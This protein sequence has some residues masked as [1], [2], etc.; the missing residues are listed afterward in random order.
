MENLIN[1]VDEALLNEVSD[2]T[3]LKQGAY[4][5]RKNGKGIERKSNENVEIIPKQDVSGIDIRVKDNVKF[6][7]IHIP[8]IITESGLKDIV[9]NDFYIGK[10]S[11]VYIIAGCGIHNDHKDNS[12][13]NGI[14]RFFLDEGADVKYIEKHYVEGEGEGKRIMNPVM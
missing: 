9:Y 6:D 8:V 10:N 4:N 12:E 3:N 7:Y 1:T 5:I 14:H 13:H 11:K 2:L